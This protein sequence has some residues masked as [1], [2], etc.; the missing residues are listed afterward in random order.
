[1]RTIPAALAAAM[2]FAAIGGAT[3]QQQYDSLGSPTPAPNQN[4]SSS[5]SSRDPGVNA[6]TGAG[7]DDLSAEGKHDAGRRSGSQTREQTNTKTQPSN[8]GG[9]DD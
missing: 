6:T 2:L 4:S 8:T 7:T 5:Q 9:V 3:A 1:M